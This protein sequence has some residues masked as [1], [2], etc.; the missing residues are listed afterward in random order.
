[1][2]SLNYQEY[3]YI[4]QLPDECAL[5]LGVTLYQQKD[6]LHFTER[7]GTLPKTLKRVGVVKNEALY[8]L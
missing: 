3:K 8:S 1:M 5:G 4:C 2:F 6:V 7:K